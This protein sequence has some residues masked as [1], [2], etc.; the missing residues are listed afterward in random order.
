MKGAIYSRLNDADIDTS[1]DV[2]SDANNEVDNDDSNDVDNDASKDAGYDA[3]ND[4]D[5]FPDLE[6]TGSLTSFHPQ[7]MIFDIFSENF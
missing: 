1:N 4:D 6:F 5:N 2:D 3:S 7:K